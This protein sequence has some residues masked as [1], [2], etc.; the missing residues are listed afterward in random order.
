MDQA[1]IG[2]SGY[3]AQSN[4]VLLI[5][6]SGNLHSPQ[7]TSKDFKKRKTEERICEVKQKQL[8]GQF[9]RGME[10]VASE[11]CWE[12]LEKCHLKKS[13]EELISGCAE[14]VT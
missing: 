9:L 6:A 10:G 5:A 4:E 2:L 1:A 3:I 7:E 14:P 8:H 11:K 12:W 13:T